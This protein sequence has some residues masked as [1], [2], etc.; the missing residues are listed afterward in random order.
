MSRIELRLRQPPRL[1]VDFEGIRPRRLAA[2]ALPEVQR[3]RVWHGNEALA[4]A[5]L[6]DV[7]LGTAQEPT[8]RL[9]GELTA[10]DRIG[11]GLDGGRI[12]IHGGVGDYLGLRMRD[13]QI[14][15][16]GTA[17]A[18]AGCEM[19]GGSMTVAGDVGDYA[20][21]ALPGSMEGMRGGRLL[22]AGNAGERAGDRM[23]RGLLLVAGNA[24]ACAAS[25]MV[26][27]TLA[28][29]GA[30]GPHAA[31]GMR[32]GTLVLARAPAALLPTFVP[33]RHDVGVFWH[34]LMRQL[35][36]AGSPWDA[37]A[38]K[39]PLRWVGDRAVGG[40]GEILVA[41]D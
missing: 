31:F 3:L 13:G 18:F 12:E 34:L 5:D 1:R 38:A 2:L 7:S 25:R 23:R 20:G 27:G 6:F 9:E 16:R 28:V 39:R 41:T 19:A 29:A 36:V 14:H 33:T 32:R 40:I 8:L 37:L 10:F 22:I 24:G 11:A 17:G 35:A 15:V 21:A 4:L 26:A 30:L